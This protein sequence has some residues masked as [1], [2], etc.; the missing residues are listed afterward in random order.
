MRLIAGKTV[1]KCSIFKPHVRREPLVVINFSSN[2]KDIVYKIT[3]VFPVAN[4]IT[5]NDI[6]FKPHYFG[7][8]SSNKQYHIKSYCSH[9]RVFQ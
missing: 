5:S 7:D 2:S 1:S 3:W 6:V 8:T 4:N 9:F